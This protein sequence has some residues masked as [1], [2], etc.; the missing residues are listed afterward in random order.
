MHTHN[1]LAINRRYLS[2][3]LHPKNVEVKPLDHLSVTVN[4]IFSVFSLNTGKS[5]RTAGAHWQMLQRIDKN[6]T[7]THN[8]ILP[9]CTR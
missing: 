8:E 5:N 7:K 3:H 4:T 6:P 2:P 9:S 1:H